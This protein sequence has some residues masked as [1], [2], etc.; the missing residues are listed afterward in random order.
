MDPK[1]PNIA[2]LGGM[3]IGAYVA[4]KTVEQLDR[5]SDY[6]RTR[7]CKKRKSRRKR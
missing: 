3:L 1:T 7:Q 5:M 2:A 4:G 6:H